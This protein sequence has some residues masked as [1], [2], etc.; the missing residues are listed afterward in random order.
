MTPPVT[1]HTITPTDADFRP[2]TFNSAA[3]ISPEKAVLNT[4]QL[5]KYAYPNQGLIL[6]LAVVLAIQHKYLPLTAALWILRVL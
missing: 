4:L 2:K 5:P 1:S 3:T 6:I